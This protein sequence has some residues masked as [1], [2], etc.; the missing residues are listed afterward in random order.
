MKKLY[1]HLIITMLLFAS[2]YG[3]AALRAQEN[4]PK[5]YTISLP[6]TDGKNYDLT[7][8][9][10]QVLVVSFGATWCQPCKEELRVLEE[11]KKEYGDRPVKFFWVSIE[12]SEEASDKRLQSFAKSVK[13]TFPILRDATR[14]TYA[15]FSERQRI[16]LVVFFDK[17]GRFAPPTHAGMST[18]ENYRR[19]VRTELERLLAD[20][21]NT[22][23]AALKAARPSN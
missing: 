6:G 11:L 21:S 9:R 19:M 12:P 4:E 3:S 23:A 22:G 14:W 17:Q 13:F 15:Q 20:K 8:M 10:G 2:H 5:D 18:P 1:L 7:Q 16:P